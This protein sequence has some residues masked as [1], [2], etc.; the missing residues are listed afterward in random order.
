MQIYMHASTL[1][2]DSPKGHSR[3]PQIGAMPMLSAHDLK[4]KHVRLLH[5]FFAAKAA[6]P[7]GIF[8]H[9]LPGKSEPPLIFYPRTPI[10]KLVHFLAIVRILWPLE[11]LQD[12]IEVI[13]LFTAV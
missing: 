13:I 12:Q 9:V 5:N 4:A 8:N 7:P 3:L 11:R 6:H 10:V 2:F 1:N